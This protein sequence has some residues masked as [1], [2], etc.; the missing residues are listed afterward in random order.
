[1]TKLNKTYKKGTCSGCGKQDTAIETN[2]NLC[3]LPRE[4]NGK[5]VEGCYILRFN[6]LAKKNLEMIHEQKKKAE[7]ASHEKVNQGESKCMTCGES[8]SIVNESGNCGKCQVKI[9]IMNRTKEMDWEDKRKHE[10]RKND[11]WK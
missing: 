4:V 2:S 8:V 3:I 7:Q 5:E 1:M 9:N 6:M 11:A 10:L